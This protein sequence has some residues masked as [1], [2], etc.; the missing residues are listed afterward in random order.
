MRKSIAPHPAKA[1]VHGRIAQAESTSEPIDYA[2]AKL[3][4]AEPGQRPGESFDTSAAERTWGVFPWSFPL[5]LRGQG[6]AEAGL[7]DRSELR[8]IK[9]GRR[10]RGILNVPRLRRA[11]R[12]P[13]PCQR[14]EVQV[15]RRG[16][17]AR[18]RG[19]AG[20]SMPA[21]ASRRTSL[22]W[23][24]RDGTGMSCSR[25]ISRSSAFV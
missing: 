17:Y 25:A 2:L 9:A 15:R 12:L 3:L 20:R 24:S 1:K 5:V 11:G 13:Q 16:A 4:V 22:S 6:R 23:V 10:K 8:R 14:C 19:L 18:R 7:R 21:P